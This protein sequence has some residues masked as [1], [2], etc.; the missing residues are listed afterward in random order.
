MDSENGAIPNH[1]TVLLKRLFLSANWIVMKGNKKS[2]IECSPR[3]LCHSW[4]HIE[5]HLLN[6][7]Q[8]KKKKKYENRTPEWNVTFN[9]VSA[10]LE[11][12]ELY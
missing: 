11:S 5:A 7:K 9:L 4:V 2:A 12:S 6:G 1:L 10:G 8:N 3:R